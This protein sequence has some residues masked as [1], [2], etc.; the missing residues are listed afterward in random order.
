[1][2]YIRQQQF[3]TTITDEDIKNHDDIANLLSAIKR[4]SVDIHIIFED[5]RSSSIISHKQVRVKK[6][7][8]AKIDIISFSKS[9][10]ITIKNIPFDN[11][12]SLKLVSETENII[13]NNK[14]ITRADLLDIE[15]E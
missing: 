1:M 9:G 2:R 8:D 11:I 6:V 12:I 14:K 13:V 15:S 3:I 5:V 4:G 10:M 7:E